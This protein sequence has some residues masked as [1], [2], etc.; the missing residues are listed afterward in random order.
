MD[1]RWY[2]TS[3]VLIWLASM[4]WLV[5]SK[6]LPALLVGD[7][8]SYR[9]IVEAQKQSPPAGWDLTLNGN[10]LGWALSMALPAADGGT[11]LQGWIHFRRLPLTDATPGWL[12]SM[13]QLMEQPLE[14]P[15]MDARS[16]FTID[17]Q[18]RLTGFRTAVRLAPFR[19]E[20]IFRGEV[21][22]TKLM[23]TVQAKD[24]V[25][26]PPTEIYL[27]PGALVGDSLT[28]QP[29]L[30]GL[31]AG[32]QWSVPIYSPLRPM[33]PVEVLQATVEKSELISWGGEVIDCWVVTY[34]NDPGAGLGGQTPPRGGVWV[35]HDGT[36][37]KQ[38]MRLFDSTLT[39]VRL[40]DE[41]A[42][43]LVKRVLAE[44]QDAET[45]KAR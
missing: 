21:E 8:P 22:G 9:A 32:Q 43:F 29:K 3:V 11:E 39:S 6:V 20:I 10:S 15:K 31:R 17:R 13:F 37:L 18:G 23:L 30:P 44:A 19:D 34:R 40:T 25:S 7:P 42:D 16:I 35:R 26:P 38:D 33:Q 27:P 12:K 2:T 41:Q 24:F 28:P 36:V 5:T 45:G 1:S 14:V 4:S